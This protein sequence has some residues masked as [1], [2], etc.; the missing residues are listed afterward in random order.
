MPDFRTLLVFASTLFLAFVLERLPMPEILSWLQPAWVILAVTIL[1][2]RAPTLFGLWLAI[3][4][5]LMLDAERGSYLGLHILII[6]L[7]IYLLQVLY[8]RIVMFNFIQQMAVVFLLVVL[9]QMLTYWV[10]SV[11]TNSTRPVDL[12]LPA[13]T[14]AM[15]WPWVYALVSTA[16]RKVSHQ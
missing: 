15:M 3:P 2:L 10:L 13:L 1:V 11:L 4:L 14:S 6:A 5:G 12:W 7:H 9:Q 16:M 8:K